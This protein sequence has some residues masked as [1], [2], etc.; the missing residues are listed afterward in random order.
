MHR[1]CTDSLRF[2][3]ESRSRFGFCWLYG[4]P[5]LGFVLGIPFWFVLEFYFKLA[6]ESSLFMLICLVALM[7]PLPPSPSMPIESAIFYAFIL[8]G[9][10]F[11]PFCAA[12][13]IFVRANYCYRSCFCFNWLAT[14]VD[15]VVVF[16]NIDPSELA[17]SSL[18]FGKFWN[19][20][21]GL[22]WSDYI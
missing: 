11:A 6:W 13:A 5:L 15:V 20:W 10:P 4:L 1:S 3:C 19:H 2:Y 7:G 17:V 22:T 18:C 12:M 8:S 21:P 14:C 9:W 16:V